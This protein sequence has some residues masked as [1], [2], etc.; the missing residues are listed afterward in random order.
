MKKT[1][2]D[3]RTGAYIDTDEEREAQS[4]D[5]SYFS[6]SEEEESYR[7][8]QKDKSAKLR[9]EKAAKGSLEQ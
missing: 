8:R 6:D 2:S 9:Q 3:L 7:L 4:S 1:L 5:Q